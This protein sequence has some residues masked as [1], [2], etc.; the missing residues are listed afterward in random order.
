M[1]GM[2]LWS[3]PGN[4][5]LIIP[6]PDQRSGAMPVH[7]DGM[8][9]DGPVDPFAA[10]LGERGTKHLI[11][12]SPRADFFEQNVLEPIGVRQGFPE[13]GG[14]IG[15]TR[16]QHVGVVLG[17]GVESE[18][19]D[20]HIAMQHVPTLNDRI[21]A[22]LLGCHAATLNS[23]DGW[24]QVPSPRSLIRCRQ[25]HTR[26]LVR[27]VPGVMVRPENISSMVVQTSWVR[28]A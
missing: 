12:G 1:P 2:T 14:G 7:A 20:A 15:L 16:Q 26:S 17:V 11:A 4:T 13:A 28:R 24:N 21:R 5:V 10:H 9:V 3:P 18:R 27:V 19:R 22:K 25:N 8:A 6:Q 23:M